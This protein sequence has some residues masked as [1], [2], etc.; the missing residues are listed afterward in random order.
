MIPCYEISENA[1]GLVWKYFRTLWI[2]HNGGHAKIELIR[3][4]VYLTFTDVSITY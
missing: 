4:G 3:F 2:N 1:V